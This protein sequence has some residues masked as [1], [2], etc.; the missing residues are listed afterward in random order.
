MRITFMLQPNTAPFSYDLHDFS[1]TQHVAPTRMY[2]QPRIFTGP[3]GFRARGRCAKSRARCT[4]CPESIAAVANIYV[5]MRVA[6][7]AA[8]AAALACLIYGGA[9]GVRGLMRERCVLQA[10]WSSQMSGAS[11]ARYATFAAT[12]LHGQ[13]SHTQSASHLQKS[14]PFAKMATRGGR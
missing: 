4:D 10:R 12:L 3:E 8:A 2:I 1:R 9:G 6:R 7:G 14:R 11:E 13:A 5:R